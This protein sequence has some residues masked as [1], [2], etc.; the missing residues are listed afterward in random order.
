MEIL[1]LM[2]LL[3]SCINQFWTHTSTDLL[4]IFPY[5]LTKNNTLPYYSRCLELGSL[6]FYLTEAIILSRGSKSSR[7]MTVKI[8]NN[9]CTIK[10]P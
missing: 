10:N 7:K 8:T 6:T 3:R 9:K 4:V 2:I 1:Y 5:Y